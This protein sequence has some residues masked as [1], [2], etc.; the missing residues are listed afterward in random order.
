MCA[1]SRRR[2]IYSGN[3]NT[4]REERDGSGSVTKQFFDWFARL[5]LGA[6]TELRAI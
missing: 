1:L 6:K 4:L 3:T 5:K 2:F